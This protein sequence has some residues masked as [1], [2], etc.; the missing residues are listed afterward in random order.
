M[1]KRLGLEIHYSR[2]SEFEQGRRFPP[3]YVLLAY[4]R[5]GGVHID[6]LVDD[7]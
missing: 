2:I 6:D 7:V 1:V 5:A 4:A 3:V